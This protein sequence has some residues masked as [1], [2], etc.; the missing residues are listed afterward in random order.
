M[1][2]NPIDALREIH[3]KATPGQWSPYVDKSDCL[4]T[5]VGKWEFFVVADCLTTPLQDPEQNAK[6]I[7]TAHNMMPVLLDLLEAVGHL[8]RE[9]DLYDSPMMD[10]YAAAMTKAK[11]VIDG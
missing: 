7:V 6:A 11:E 2:T 9:R 8:R 5:G 1:M 10:A 3:E 4:I